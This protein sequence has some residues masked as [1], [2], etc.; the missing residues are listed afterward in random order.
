MGV[1]ANKWVARR[2]LAAVAAS[3]TVLL[4]GGALAY[5]EYVPG[6]PPAVDPG[7]PT[8]AG[9]A[10]PVPPEPVAYDPA[11]SMMK[12]IFDAGPATN[13]QY[14]FDSILERPFSNQAGETTLL[15]RGRA[16]YMNNHTPGTLGFA[17]GYAYRE[18]PTG[19]SQS[20][21]TVTI[22][23]QTVTETTA[24]RLQW[25][26]YFTGAFT[27]ASLSIAETK[28][29]TQNN[30]A[31]TELKLTN[32]GTDP[33]TRTI[34]VQSPI[35]TTAAGN[36]LTGSVT[37]RYGLTTVTSRLSSEGFTA[38]GTALTRDVSLDPG[39]S[40]TLKVQM[41]MIAAELPDSQSEYNRYK[42]YD[43]DAALAAQKREYNAFWSDNVPYV[44]IPD[45]NVKKISYYR[46][47]ENRFNTFDGNIPG[48]DYQFPV[49]LE[50]A[51]G[52]NNQI[53]LT[54][55]MRMQDLKWWTDPIW[56][57]GQ[58][59]SQGEESGCQ[60][61]H[62][63]PGN[64]ANWN[65]TYEQWTADEAFEAYKVHGGPKSILKNLAKYSECDVKGTLA[66][67]DSNGNGTIEYT[68]GTLPGN[69]ADSVAFQQYGTRRQDRTET[70]FWYSG[71]KAAAEEYQMLGEDA[72]ATEMDGIADNIKSGVMNLWANDPI[73][74]PGGAATGPRA[75]GKIGKAVA[76]SGSG[77]WVTLPNNVTGTLNGNWSV[78]TWVNPQAN[79]TW[80]RIFDFGTG[81]TRYMFLTVSAGSA[82]RFAISTGG[83]GAAEQVING[84]GTLP[85]NQ[86][87]HVAIVVN[88]N[89]G[90]LYVNGTA[91]GTNNNITIH[92]SDLGNTTQNWI[93]RSQ[94]GDPLLRATVDDFN[95]Y[96]R[97]LSADDITALA[98]GAAGTG[99]VADYK[100]DEADGATAVDS[101][102]NARN[103]TINTSAPI[104]CPGKAFLQRDLTT[105]NLVCWKDQQNFAPF[106]DG[107]APNTDEYKQ[108][109]RYY[110]D[111]AQFPLMPAYTANQADKAEAAAH[112]STGSNNFSNINSTLQARLF[113]KALRDYPSQ[114]ITPDS[115][116]KL[117]EWLSWNE[118]INGDNRFP[119]NNEYFFNWNPTTQ[120]LGRSGI[121]H[122][123]LGSFN[124]IMFQDVAGITPRL[125]D[126]IELN[127]IDW[128]YDHF[129]VNNLS[130]HG[131][132]L[133]VVWQ[134]PGGTRYYPLAPDG[135]SLYVGGRRVATVDDLTHLTWNS[136]T[137]HVELLGST[138]AHVNYS[139]Q[140]TLANA[141]EVSL[142]DNPRLV[143]SFQKAG[144]DIKP[145]TSGL[146]NLAQ[147]KTATASYTTTTPASQATSPANAVDGFTI[148]GIPVTSGAYVG[149]NPIWGD[150]GS[151]NASDWLQ[152]DL[153][154]PKRFNQVKLYFF[155]NKAW[156]ASG[157]TYKEPASY[158]IQYFDGANW[159]DVP[160]QAKT[161]AAPAPNY[162]QVDFPFITAQ[163]MRVMVTKSTSPARAV[164]I[165]EVQVFDTGS[166][167][168]APGGVGGTVPATLSLTLGAPASFGAFTPGV[169]KTY[170]S[171]T[172]ANVI[173]T[174]G[175]AALSVADPS[176]TATGHLV[177]GAF[178]LP[179]ALQVRARNATYPAPAFAPVG[180][181]ASPL[182][183]LSYI[184]PI[185]NDA[186]TIDFRQSIAAN[187]ALRTGTY[188][189]TLVFTLSTTTP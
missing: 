53:S 33:I 156:G 160:G 87:S 183:L 97:A 4:G 72:K 110:A 64:T 3:A 165:K 19:A 129:T 55:P 2:R 163:Q 111:K 81:T 23:G 83:G 99:D 147:G 188:A 182:A 178:S 120:T 130:Y 179:D 41:G 14:W 103:A 61:F 1:G 100:F 95:I 148:S 159:V 118:Y 9:L 42:G 172:T 86:W 58:W 34:S 119:D 82:L 10:N 170:E 16:L 144:V 125:D 175:D 136:K 38:N 116:R 89:V 88:G 46:T 106:I 63:N 74:T 186:V 52:Y 62:D 121:H 143:D 5:A 126:V 128:G 57:Y 11:K 187:D 96:G 167:V 12:A 18:R 177:N 189:K 25:P 138:T 17:G 49:D 31:V 24:S 84:T 105:G 112:G 101:S 94:Y 76:L 79:T 139:A 20:L 8:F 109:L 51:L 65:N 43:A 13:G 166:Q 45:A 141:T 37:I 151:P 68:S 168:Q 173:S 56:S 75:E 155:S 108:A 50:G 70:S 27:S 134:K 124:W 135:Y 80:S 90:T 142:S 115:Y 169:A 39:A 22:P 40:A 113:S 146:V 145:Q 181:A 71:A 158:S 15:T 157:S 107:I 98:G 73:S 161:P 60:A 29:I 117:I 93:G 171:A 176:S 114:Y 26:S 28:F 92:P 48:N 153:G 185:S 131:T 149:T 132:S 140:G 30:T 180:S 69:D 47:W 137:G 127:P 91:V 162:N 184:A 152:I 59:L 78:S 102:A 35:A 123:V 150:N 32:T 104:S 85:L 7:T 66:K 154:A 77:E 164:G 133:T 122:D 174:A 44:D 36:E 54:V 21:Y 6:I 67:F